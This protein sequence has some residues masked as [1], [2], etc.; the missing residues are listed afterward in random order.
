MTEGSFDR[1]LAAPRPRPFDVGGELQAAR[2]IA[3][4]PPSHDIRLDLILTEAEAQTERD[5]T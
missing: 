2:L 4:H 1:T 3:I 5:L